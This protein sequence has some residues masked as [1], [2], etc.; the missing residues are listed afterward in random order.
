MAGLRGSTGG[1]QPRAATPA[2][3]ARIIRRAQQKPADGSTHWSYRKLAEELGISKSTVQR[4]LAQAQ[5][6]PH[7]LDRYMASN[8]PEFETKAADITAIQALEISRLLRALR[9]GERVASTKLV[10]SGRSG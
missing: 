8:D 7:R 5:L 4:V 3:Q 6:R 9:C 2:V 1:S 10:H